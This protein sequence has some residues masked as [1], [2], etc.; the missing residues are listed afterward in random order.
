MYSYLT[1][2]INR[3]QDSLSKCKKSEA[4]RPR[5]SEKLKYFTSSLQVLQVLLLPMLKR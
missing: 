4:R 1:I 3:R 5:T 2:R